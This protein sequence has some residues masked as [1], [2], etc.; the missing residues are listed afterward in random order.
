MKKLLPALAILLLGFGCAPSRSPAATANAAPSQTDPAAPAPVVPTVGT[1]TV[2]PATSG[3]STYANAS[4]GFALDFPTS[5]KHDEY[6]LGQDVSVVAFD[7]SA[8]I[9]QDEFASFDK[10]PGR[11]VVAATD[12]LPAGSIDA[13]TV[14]R[15]IPAKVVMTRDGNVV[16]RIYYVATPAHKI[17]EIEIQYPASAESDAAQMQAVNGL[18]ASFR[19]LN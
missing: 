3:L 8:V 2:S 11:F 19:F 9:T 4:L 18:L 14:G 15:G 16:H 1:G 7:P 13:T 17:L 10:A 5:W 12:A 6:G